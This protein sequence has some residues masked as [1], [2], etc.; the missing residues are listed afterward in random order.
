M[1]VASP[2]TCVACNDAMS[3]G[4]VHLATRVGRQ[5]DFYVDSTSHDT[6]TAA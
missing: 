2:V 3:C 6:F 4:D 1:L 5:I